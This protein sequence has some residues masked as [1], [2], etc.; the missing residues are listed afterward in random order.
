MAEV[1]KYKQLNAAVILS[2]EM[3]DLIIVFNNQSYICLHCHCVKSCSYTDDML[4][5]EMTVVVSKL[6]N[7]RFVHTITAMC[8]PT[9]NVTC[10]N[11]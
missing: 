4:H 2:F 3:V 10:K 9:Q 1:C 6:L 8:D 5:R 7:T 11:I